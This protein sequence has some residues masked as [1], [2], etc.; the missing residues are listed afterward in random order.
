M[1]FFFIILFL[2]NIVLAEVYRVDNFI[3]DFESGWNKT[4]GTDPN[5]SLRIEKGSFYAEFIKLEDELSDFYI[6][7][8]LEEQKQQIE[9][10]AL[11]PTSIKT[12][13]IHTK[14]K[15]Y[16]FNYVDKKESTIAMFSYDGITY[17]FI[18]IGVS[19]DEFKKM[20]FTFRKDGETIE[21]PKPQPKP[22]KTIAKPKPIE[23]TNLGYIYIE[24]KKTE[25][26][27]Q[28]TTNANQ[29]IS[30]YTEL[31]VSYQEI[32]NDTSNIEISTKL[33]INEVK[34]EESI[35][36]KISNFIS[37]TKKD[38][39]MI[40]ERK[41]LNPY[42]SLFLVI[43]YISVSYFFKLK[44]S[45]YSNLKIKPYPKELPPDFLFPFIITRLKT[46]NELIYQII[47]RTNQ[48]LSAT[49]SFRYWRYYPNS[50]LYLIFFHLIWSLS[51][52]FDEK[53]FENIFLTIPFGNYFLSFIEIPFI[54]LYIFT[55]YN[56]F[57][58]KVKL[59][60]KDSQ[61]NEITTLI[62][63][64]DGF[65][66]KDSKGR[67]AIKVK[68]IG[69]WKR[70]YT[71]LDEDNKIFMEIIDER[72]DV[73]IAVK[74]LGNLLIKKRCYYSIRNEKNDMVGFL[75]LDPNSFDS[76]QVH[77]DFDYMRLVNSVQLVASILYI[78]STDR[79]ENIL[80]L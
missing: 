41:P 38:T 47:T 17:S 55:L 1:K 57:I 39:K 45:N 33:V 79:E 5:S 62:K 80:S 49:I 32:T 8:R 20:I 28:S 40:I 73:W 25:E 22:K 23:E 71:F 29:D 67:D 54:A 52:L 48:V 15:A 61:M 44:F 27:S 30:T 12:T 51:T 74:I 60:V 14:S 56:K 24:D 18:S 4:K 63:T 58:S 64:S 50:F 11:K 69:F 13:N 68:K 66:V 10:K 16:Y 53:L 3:F 78:I 7:S 43:M 75:Y 37:A 21:I 65:I 31:T 59:S 70:R 36:N 76:Y 9:S 26:L 35:F 42:I 46:S 77:F 72:P 6:K 34:K 19:E 2:K